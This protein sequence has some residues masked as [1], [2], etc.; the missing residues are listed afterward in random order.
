MPKVSVIVPNY[1]HAPYLKL[2]IDSVLQQSFQD[3]ELIILDDCSTDNSREIIEQYRNHPKVSH[4]DYNAQNTNSTFRQWRKGFLLA[5]GDYIWVAESDDYADE[6]FLEKTVAVL[7][8]HGQAALC[9]VQ[10]HVVNQN[11]ESRGCYEEDSDFYR[12]DFCLDGNALIQSEFV[13]KNIIPNASAVLFRRENLT[14]ID[15]EKMFDFK[16]NGDWYLWI[17]MLKNGYCAY[18]SE[19]LSCF[20]RHENAGSFGN[21]RNFRNIEEAMRISVFL[22]KSGVKLNGKHWLSLWLRQAQYSA[23]VLWRTNF[24]NIY[25]QSVKLNPLTLPYLFY[26]LLVYR[27][28]NI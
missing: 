1:N 21:I 18:L 22:K 26:K 24:R 19:P 17:S 9:F 25:R 27:I 4:I 23:S 5:Q 16:I 8:K 7:E 20:R 15:L 28:K 3:F 11:G 6:T 2:R 10:S 14:K 12:N 13:F